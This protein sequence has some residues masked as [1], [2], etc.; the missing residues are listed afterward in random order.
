[1]AD[2]NTELDE[3]RNI[4]KDAADSELEELGEKTVLEIDLRNDSFQLAEFPEI[5]EANFQIPSFGIICKNFSLMWGVTNKNGNTFILSNDH[6]K[7]ALTEIVRKWDVWEKKKLNC[8][9]LNPDKTLS[10]FSKEYFSKGSV[11][12]VFAETQRRPFLHF[13]SAVVFTA[14]HN[15]PFDQNASD[16]TLK[17]KDYEIALGKVSQICEMNTELSKSIRNFSTYSGTDNFIKGGE[18]VLFYG[19]PGTGKSHKVQ[20]KIDEANAKAFRT[21]FHPDLQNSDFFGCLKPWC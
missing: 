19:A 16:M 20:K 11:H 8:N 6:L 1:M 17:Q 2:P 14:N 9:S 21:V 13:I 3:L 10:D 12:A 7:N 4:S 18:N 15:R 5:V